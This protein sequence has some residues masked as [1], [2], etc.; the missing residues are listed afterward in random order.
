MIKPYLNYYEQIN[1]L[2]NDKGLIIESEVISSK[3]V[4]R[5]YQ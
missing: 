4:K 3:T 1:K 2:K 5:D